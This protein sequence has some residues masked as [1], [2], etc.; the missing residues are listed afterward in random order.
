MSI[1]NQYAAE[2]YIIQRLKTKFPGITVASFDRLSVDMGQI[3]D[4]VGIFVRP[5]GVRKIKDG[6][7]QD[8]EIIQPWG[9]MVCVPH[10]K[11]V[12]TEETT[13]IKAGP[14]TLKI[15]SYFAGWKIPVIGMGKLSLKVEQP[16]ADFGTEGYASFPLIF[17]S[18]FTI[19]SD[20]T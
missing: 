15:I 19:E 2:P 5:L 1:D 4:P 9:I 18:T 10:V 17:D 13:A 11:G 8:P 7:G 12:D 16:D 3:I 14:Y 20:L 6:N